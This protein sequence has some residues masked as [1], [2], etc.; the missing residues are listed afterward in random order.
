MADTLLEL[1]RLRAGEGSSRVA[2]R[3][4]DDDGTES[5]T[6]TYTELDR[7]ARA[8]GAWLEEHHARGERALL[9][10]PPG[11][12][13]IAAFFG[14][15]YA[16]VTAVPAY[17]PRLNRPV[18]RIQAI[19]DDS[20][21]KDAAFPTFNEILQDKLFDFARLKRVQVQHAV[22]WQLNWL[23]IHAK[24]FKHVH[25]HPPSHTC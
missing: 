21:A 9:L 17:P 12:D 19:V 3:Y 6:F 22:N 15:L 25:D 10:Y 23:V 11:L 14:C 24:R 8:I 4:L 2:Y 7:R 16:G 20:H 1:L 18:P 13:Y 5:S